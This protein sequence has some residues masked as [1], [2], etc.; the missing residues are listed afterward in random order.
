MPH[1]ID[2]QEFLFDAN[3]TTGMLLQTYCEQLDV[4][5]V[6]YRKLH[7]LEERIELK[8]TV[9]GNKGAARAILLHALGDILRDVEAVAAGFELAAARIG[10]QLPCAEARHTVTAA[11]TST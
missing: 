2:T 1:L 9:H 10:L 8:L 6:A 5:F 11:E 4:I 7:P 3:H